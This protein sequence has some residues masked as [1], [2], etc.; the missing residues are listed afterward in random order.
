M[1]KNL[2]IIYTLVFPL[3]LLIGCQGQGLGKKQEQEQEQNQSKKT[4]LSQ[5]KTLGDEAILYARANYVKL[6]YEINPEKFVDAYNKV[7]DFNNVA[8][9]NIIN[10]YNI[11]VQ[12]LEAKDP[13]SKS[14]LESCKALSEFS[15]KLVDQ[16]Y[17]QAMSFKDSSKLNP[18]TDDFFLEINKII[19][20][21]LSIGEYKNTFVDFKTYVK[22]Y[23]TALK[24]YIEKY[25]NVL[26]EQK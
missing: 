25:K 8:H 17:P 20:F 19:K 22:N 5:C 14:F 7:K 6:F 10:S 3:L 16:D 4:L 18:L 12:K 26:I 21:D 24:E 11:A 23:K 15:Q 2:F 13:I 9:R 1:I